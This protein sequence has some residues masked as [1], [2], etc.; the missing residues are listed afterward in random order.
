[1]HFPIRFAVTTALFA[2]SIHAA[3]ASS[4]D[5]LNL[6]NNYNLITSGDTTSYSHVD[7]KALIG[8]N[9]YGGDYNMHVIPNPVSSLT[10]AG[11]IVGNVQTKGQGLNVGGGITG[12][13]NMNDGGNAYVGSV[14][15]GG[16]LNN[17][18]N[19]HG[20]TYV[21]GDIAGTVKTNSG[22]T[23]YGGNLTGYAEANGGGSVQH[24]AI[25]TP[26]NPATQASDAIATLSAFSAQLSGIGAN[27]AYNFLDSDT[28]IF[29]AVA[30]SNGLAAFTISD[31]N[32]FFNQA[33]EFQFNL[34][35]GV[36]TILLNV[37]N[38]DINTVLNVHANFLGGSAVNLG[39]NMLWNFQ[40]ASK[41]DINAQ[42]GGSLLALDADVITRGNIEGTLVAKS[43]I[44]GTEI[45][46]QGLY[47]DAD[48][49]PVP[50]NTPISST[51]PLPGTIP[52]L[53]IGLAGFGATYR[54]S[55]QATA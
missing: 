47:A 24:Q 46:Y 54:R 27:S 50:Q 37:I 49:F 30:D 19:G 20:S 16:N 26:L 34:A 2:G 22:N 51:V 13:V 9:L 12:S 35:S 42:F 4:V 17:N 43:L 18:A 41:I 1:M 48:D 45:H 25:S 53:A 11:N 7:G 29:D 14:A 31:A 3:H 23:V 40:N 44:Q 55:R 36:Q 39:K 52:L 5:A 33:G 32:S 21:V 15:N 6:L 28:V 8:G 38:S 10:V